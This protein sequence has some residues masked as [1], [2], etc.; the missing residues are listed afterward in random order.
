LDVAKT[1]EV[2]IPVPMDQYVTLGSRPDR[3]R[4]IVY[5][6]S[7][8]MDELA[9]AAGRRLSET[10]RLVDQRDTGLNVVE[11]VFRA[12]TVKR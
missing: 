1:A 7:S 11:M 9:A 6:A 10:P 8:A 5:A 12:D 4:E 3:V 2:K